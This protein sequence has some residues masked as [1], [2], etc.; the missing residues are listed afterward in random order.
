MLPVTKKSKMRKRTRRSHHAL[1][2]VQLVA[3]RQCGQ[4][5]RPHLACPNCGYVNAHTSVKLE[6]E[7]S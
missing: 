2:A 6:K 5:R 7:E 4:A 1:R 3:C